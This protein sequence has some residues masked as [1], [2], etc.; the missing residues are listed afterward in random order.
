MYIIQLGAQIEVRSAALKTKPVKIK[1]LRRM[2]F[3]CIAG[4]GYNGMIL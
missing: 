3:A 4:T 1:A 2:E